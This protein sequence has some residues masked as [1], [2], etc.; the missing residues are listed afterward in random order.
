[1]AR[2]G[3]FAR[4]L[5]PFGSGRLN[6]DDAYRIESPRESDG[7]PAPAAPPPSPDRGGSP[8][9][10]PTPKPPRVGKTPIPKTSAKPKAVGKRPAPRK[11]VGKA[12]ATV[13]KRGVGTGIKKRALPKPPV[14]PHQMS[15]PAQERKA[16]RDRYI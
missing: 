14:R 11:T 9:S 8:T 7:P 16:Y 13:A 2:T 3:K 6:L 10:V 4:S 12:A 15:A 5:S 1:V